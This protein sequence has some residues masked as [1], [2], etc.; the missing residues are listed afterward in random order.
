MALSETQ[1]FGLSDTVQKLF[2]EKRDLLVK[3]RLDVDSMLV[4][5]STDHE[6]ATKANADQEAAK[7]NA[8]EKTERFVA[9][10]RKLYVTI[11]S[12]L[13]MAIGAVRKDSLAAKNFQRL[14]SRIRRPDVAEQI[15]R[16]PTP[17]A[18]A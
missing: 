7:L 14:R 11:S 9:A 17:E 5:M 15:A 16:E 10:K 13:D 2:R 3:A 8:R 1:T 18:T 6:D 4:Q 12:C